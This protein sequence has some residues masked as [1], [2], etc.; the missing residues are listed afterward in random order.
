[1]PTTITTYNSFVA[2]TKARAS[3]VNVNFSNHRGNL[4]PI[5]EATA[6]ASHN[7]HDLGSLTHQW[8]NLYL[9]QSPYVNGS[10]LAVT[11]VGAI[12]PFAGLSAPA[13][14]LMCDGSA[15]S[16]TTYATMFSVI[17][18]YWGAGNL[19]TTFNIPDLRGRFIEGRDAGVARDLG[20]ST[21][22]SSLALFT[23][24]HSITTA[25]LTQSGFLTATV[26]RLRVGYRAWATGGIPTCT[27]ASINTATGALTF[28]LT[29]TAA[30]TTATFNFDAGGDNVGST[31]L[32][33]FQGH[34]HADTATYGKKNVFTASTGGGGQRV[35]DDVATS[36]MSYFP[37]LG[38]PAVTLA[39]DT[40][41]YG[42]QTRPINAYVN[43][44]IKY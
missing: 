38:N 15:V 44:L 30:T 32:D 2:G 19:S 26:G 1:L 12:I 40:P 17:E 13:G 4:F 18:E 14:F 9:H 22:S 8:E 42:S 24:S 31:Q 37:V 10:Q 23:E 16:R 6:T 35:I 11:P 41:R 29:S 25:T 3:E 7:T 36:T 34:D 43:F 21:R 27:I 5:E 39:I 20:A 33:Q 28:S